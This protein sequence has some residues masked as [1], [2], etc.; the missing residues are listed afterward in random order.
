MPKMLRGRTY[1]GTVRR[2][3]DTQRI[4]STQASKFSHQDPGEYARCLLD[5]E[6]SPAVAIPDIATYPISLFSIKQEIPV[7][8]DLNGNGGFRLDLTSLPQYAITTAAYTFSSKVPLDSNADIA[9]RYEATRLVAASARV[10]FQGNDAGNSGTIIGTSYAR[11]Y[12]ETGFLNRVESAT[13]ATSFAIQR[14]SRNTYIGPSKDGIY[15]TY[16]PI[17]PLNNIFH[18]TQVSAETDAINYGTLY[19]NI[20]GCPVTVA[21]TSATYLAYVTLHFEG[22]WRN[23]TTSSSNVT[24]EAAPVSNQQEMSFTSAIVPMFPIIGSNLNFRTGVFAKYATAAA[25]FIK[26]YVPSISSMLSG[27]RMSK[28][29]TD[30]YLKRRRLL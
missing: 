16:R 3:G 30:R 11:T 23:P 13:P 2:D 20:Q 18:T 7:T 28:S 10:E 5:P 21:A 19:I 26:G 27:F 17:D 8:I 9:V 12:T 1:Q 15:V 22:L 25:D 6:E 29:V 24:P 4:I 14:N